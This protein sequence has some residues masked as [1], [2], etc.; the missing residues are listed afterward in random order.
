MNL[1]GKLGYILMQ[2]PSGCISQ[3]LNPN[4]VSDFLK[5]QCTCCW[6]ALGAQQPCRLVW[7]NSA[8]HQE[9][10]FYKNHFV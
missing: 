2:D 6:K 1:C 9:A 7:M 4:Q 5:H 10:Q 3:A 8:T